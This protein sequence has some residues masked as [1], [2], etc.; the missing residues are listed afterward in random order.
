MPEN[1]MSS[2]QAICVLILFTLGSSL[3]VGV[4]TDAKQDSW[5]A[6]LIALFLFSPMLMTYARIVNLYPGQNLY[7]IVLDVFGKIFGKIIIFLYVLYSI[8]LGALVMRNFSEFIQVVAMPETPQLVLLVFMFTICI[9]MVK[10]GVETLGRWAKFII[11][12]VVIAILATSLLSIK[13]MDLS[14]IKPIGG[15][16]FGALMNS[17]TSIF[18]FPFA[19][20]VLFT[21]LFGSIKA[22]SME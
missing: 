3:V 4:N 6:I 15:T 13:F 1:L 21:T 9:W 10:S 19:E 18:S 22:N 14:N 5:I 7:D 12:I 11:P 16:D 20:T 17:S 2:K 8:H